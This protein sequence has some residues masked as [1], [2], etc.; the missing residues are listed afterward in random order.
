PVKGGHRAMGSTFA[1]WQPRYAE[2]GVATFPVVIGASGKKPGVV[3]YL[4]VGLKASGQLAIKFPDAS[5]FG[6]S[7][8]KYNRI[9]VVDM[10]D[11]DPA[12]IRGA[13]R[14][15][16]RSPLIWRTGS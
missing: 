5:S 6:F 4:R 12:I 14:L 15:F 3:G 10:D 16:G 9:T 2:R 8:G 11:T 1:D 13:E 7:C